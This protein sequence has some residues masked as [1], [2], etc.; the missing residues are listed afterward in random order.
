MSESDGDAAGGS[1]DSPDVSSGAC[2]VPSGQSDQMSAASP[3]RQAF[4]KAGV[5]GR[6]GTSRRKENRGGGVSA[7]GDGADVWDSENRE[8]QKGKGGGAEEGVSEASAATEGLSQEKV[9][10]TCDRR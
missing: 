9:S 8:V 5:S 1:V 3:D 10:P 7:S 2:G 4:G 6:L